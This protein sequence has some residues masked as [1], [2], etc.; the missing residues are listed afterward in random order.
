[1]TN[2]AQKTVIV[3]GGG[4]AGLSAA[5]ELAKRGYAVKV[6]EAKRDL[7]GKARSQ[8]VAGTGKGGRGDL[9]GEHGFRFYP[10]FYR[11]LIRTMEEIPIDPSDLA[12]PSVA[13]RLR[14]CSEAGIGPADG[15]G[16]RR[17]LRRSPTGMA[18]VAGTMELYF[19]DL[20]VG[21]LD[22]AR[23]TLRVIRYFCACRRRRDDEYERISWWDYVE[24]SRY[25]PGFQ[26]YIRAI[27]RIMVAMDPRSGSARTIGDISMQLLQD[28]ASAGGHQ[29]RT[30]IGPTSDAW[31]RP[32]QAS[33]AQGGVEFH[34]GRRLL[35][36]EFDRKAGRI[37]GA[38]IEGEPELVRGDSYVLAVP[39]EVAVHVV[40]DSM[41][42]YDPEI[43]KLVRIRDLHRED[44][45]AVLHQ[46]HDKMTD[47]MVGIQFYLRED[48]RLVR[49]H[50]FLPDSPWALSA[51]SQEQFWLED[52]K[53][54]FRSRFGDG[55][56]GG[57]LSVDISDWNSEGTFVKK[58]AKLCSREEIVTEVWGQLKAGLN[59]RGTPVLTD[60]LIAS[61]HLDDDIEV[62]GGALTN[63]S[64]LLVHPPGSWFLRPTAA[65]RIENLALAS[66]YV[67]TSTILASM[68]GANEAARRAVNSLVERDGQRGSPCDVWPLAEGPAFD[69]MK[70][71]DDTAYRDR[72]R[73]PDLIAD[74]ED[75]DPA[76]PV[77]FEDLRALQDRIATM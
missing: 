61:V 48:H 40:D 38:R 14:A 21:P 73:G 51:I 59:K 36:L 42:I 47:W 29:D 27:P 76:K 12:G 45:S 41:A 3:L 1:M 66:D 24:G 31:I 37:T 64:P 44:S 60:D 10:A 32:W 9:P 35:G 68:E 71:L 75:R 34:T 46:E 67:Q 63:H 62:R 22:A 33:L 15:L 72:S 54:S 4:V 56:V 65:L 77:T 11:H 26:R 8:Y 13:S 58:P 5:H 57:V 23:F 69:R 20:G 30:L 39:L 25:D 74:L 49:G 43:E 50:I 52:G 6:Y 2:H 16:L 55:S 28:Y 70:Q 53:G 7:G 19:K 17:F 18:D